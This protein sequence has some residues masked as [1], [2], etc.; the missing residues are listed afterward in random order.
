MIKT[1]TLVRLKE[2][3]RYNNSSRNSFTKKAQ[4][5]LSICKD[6]GE[7]ADVISNENVPEAEDIFGDWKADQVSQSAHQREPGGA[8]QSVK[9]IEKKHDKK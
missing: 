8:V 7:T 3:V 6:F 4:H 1:A 9:W 2:H 5:Y